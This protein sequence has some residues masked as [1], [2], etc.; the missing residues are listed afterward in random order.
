MNNRIVIAG[1]GYA[2][3]FAAARLSQS[4]GMKVTLIDASPQFTERVRLHEYLAGRPLKSYPYR[5]ICKNMGLEFIQGRITKLQPDQQSLIVEGAEGARSVTYDGL[6]YALGSRTRHAPDMP[7]L[8]HHAFRLDAGHSLDQAR[9]RLA[10]LPAG[11]TVTVLGAGLTGL[12]AATEIKEAY[13]HLDVALWEAG[14]AFQNYAPGAA[15]EIRAVLEKLGVSLHENHRAACVREDAVQAADGSWHAS[16]F[17]L[18][19]LG[20]EVAPLARESGIRT[21]ERGQIQVDPFLRSLS[22][23]NILALGDAAELDSRSALFQRMSCA[24]ACPMGTYAADVLQRLQSGRK[25][26]PFRFGFTAR[27]LSLGR[28]AALVQMVNVRDEPRR[29]YFRGRLAVW[30]K[31]MICRATVNVPLW[32]AR[33]G[34]ALNQWYQ[35]RELK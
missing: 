8:D 17:T 23:P 12:E 3:L 34:L 15:R 1:G 20:L 25:L 27:C 6:L 14:L 22:H 21:N 7:G 13:P 29:L 24:A 28:K 2:G 4:S 30:I 31:E 9:L 18:N 26:L 11:R 10:A 32:E 35:P 5:E 33:S 19:C 16:A